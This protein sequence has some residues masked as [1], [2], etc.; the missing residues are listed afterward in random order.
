MAKGNDYE[1]PSDQIDLEEASV[2]L[3]VTPD[4][5]QAMVEEGLLPTAG[6]TGTGMRFERAEVL[7]V[8][9][10]GG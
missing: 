7:A 10:M 4:R 1:R 9:Q 5:V 2:I 6:G 8:R 3:E